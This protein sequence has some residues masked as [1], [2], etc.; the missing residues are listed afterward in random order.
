MGTGEA[1]PAGELR[2]LVEPLVLQELFPEDVVGGE[3]VR[4]G[5]DCPVD[6]RQ[7]LFSAGAFPVGG[8]GVPGQEVREP[9]PVVDEHRP[10][11]RHAAV[12]VRQGGQKVRPVR[13]VPQE[14]GFVLMEPLVLREG[15]GVP[16]PELGEG[17]VQEAPALRRPRPDELEVLRGEEDGP[18]HRAERRGRL[19]RDLVDAH[20][21]PPPPADFKAADELPL[22][23]EDLPL[24]DKSLRAEADELLICPR[25]VALGAGEAAEGLQEVGLPL[26]VLPADDVAGRVEGHGL[27]SVV[28]EVLQ[29][30]AINPHGPPGTPSPGR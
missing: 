20:G 17:C 26:G 11:L 10:R 25:P 28:P 23:G 21:L 8:G 1:L 2:R 22:P 18:Q 6:R 3:G 27:G 14:P 4:D 5:A 7:L 15:R 12:E 24:E 19:G 29:I 9:G 13:A 16:G 30:Y